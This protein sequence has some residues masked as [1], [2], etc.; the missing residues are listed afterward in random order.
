MQGYGSSV[1]QRWFEEN[2]PIG[3]LVQP[4]YDMLRESPEAL[5]A[6]VK[7]LVQHYFTEAD[8]NAAMLLSELGLSDPQL[9]SAFEAASFAARAAEYQRLCGRAF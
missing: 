1:P 2:K 3:G 7:V 9:P 8:D 5:D 6:A 4:V